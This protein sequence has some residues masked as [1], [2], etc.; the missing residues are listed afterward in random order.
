MPDAGAV[1]LPYGEWWSASVGS[2]RDLDS[3]RLLPMPYQVEFLCWLRGHGIE[4]EDTFR[5]EYTV[6]DCPM[7]RVWRYLADEDGKRYVEPGTDVI[8]HRVTD[9]AVR[10][11]L[12]EW[13]R[14]ETVE[15]PRGRRDVGDDTPGKQR[16]DTGG[17]S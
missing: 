12:P 4:P 13:W 10:L 7:I 5:V 15:S 2:G 11:P 3:I 6:I 14:P 8:A 16:P 9:H 17:S 1:K